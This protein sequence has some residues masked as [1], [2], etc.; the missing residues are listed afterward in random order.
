MYD[1]L[2]LNSPNFIDVHIMDINIEP[3]DTN[4]SE[5]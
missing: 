2:M 3:D 5:Q 4:K 1:E